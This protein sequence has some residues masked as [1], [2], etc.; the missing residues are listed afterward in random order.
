[1]RRRLER[2]ARTGFALG[3]VGL[4]ARGNNVDVTTV[5]R[6]PAPVYNALD[7]PLGCDSPDPMP[8]WTTLD[9]TPEW[10]CTHWYPQPQ[11]NLK[12][13]GNVS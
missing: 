6:M 9:M 5:G 12:E 4:I 13:S 2:A 10:R 1:M 8:L 7:G 3:L 11:Y